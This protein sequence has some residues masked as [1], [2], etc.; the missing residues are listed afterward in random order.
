MRTKTPDEWAKELAD[1]AG[2][3]DKKSIAWCAA[4]V[5]EIRAA[6]FREAAD[7][8]DAHNITDEQIAKRAILAI[9]P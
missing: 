7:E 4:Q 5:K 6:A 3:I 2:V 8:M 1:W 9:N